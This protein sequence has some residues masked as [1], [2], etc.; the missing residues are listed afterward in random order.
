MSDRYDKLNHNALMASIGSMSRR[1]NDDL[2]VAPPQ[3]MNDF[4]ELEGP[5]GA[6][7]AD[8]LGAAINQVSILSNAIRLTSYIEPEP[9]PDHVIE[10]MANELGGP[11]P[12]NASTGLLNLTEI[13]DE[14]YERLS[15]LRMTDWSREAM[16][17]SEVISINALARGVSRVNAERLSR[18]SRTLQALI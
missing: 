12:A 8:D 3:S 13:N 1:W 16:W 15:K 4:F 18:A 6:V 10:A 5:S 9:L 17:G 2:Y 11:R 7:I 14:V